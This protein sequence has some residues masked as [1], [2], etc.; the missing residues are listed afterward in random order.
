MKVCVLRLHATSVNKRFR[1]LVSMMTIIQ[2][3]E[4]M[5]DRKVGVGVSVRLI[6]KSAV[7]STMELKTRES[8]QKS[9]AWPGCGPAVYQ[10]LSRAKL[11]ADV[12]T[13]NSIINYRTLYAHL[14][15]NC[16]GLHVNHLHMPKLFVDVRSSVR[17]GVACTAH[18]HARETCGVQ[19]DTVPLPICQRAL[20]ET[21]PG[22]KRLLRCLL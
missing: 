8:C 15:N 19:P 12:L 17:N 16:Q 10:S 11:Y 1:G 5:M 2:H 13:S 22:S 18:E 6:T 21:T 3:H 4:R 20:G 9:K 14:P 7:K